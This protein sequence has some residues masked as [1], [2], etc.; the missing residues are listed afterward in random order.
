LSNPHPLHSLSIHT[1]NKKEILIKSTEEEFFLILK[2]KTTTLE[3]YNVGSTMTDN[4]T[5]P[6]IFNVTN[7]N[8][9]W[10]KFDYPIEVWLHA[11][12]KAPKMDFGPGL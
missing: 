3:N 2:P 4:T 7:Y 8:A 11:T 5:Q 1:Q 10:D 6:R 9:S 12:M